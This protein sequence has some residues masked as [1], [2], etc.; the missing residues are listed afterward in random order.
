MWVH[1]DAPAHCRVGAT[2]VRAT[3]TL[4]TCMSA[5]VCQTSIHAMLSQKVKGW[6]WGQNVQHR[7]GW[8]TDTLTPSSTHECMPTAKSSC[9]FNLPA[10][11]GQVSHP[12]EDLGV[13]C[14]V[15]MRRLQREEEGHTE[16]KSWHFTEN[17]NNS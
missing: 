17:I 14:L 15:C 7:T 6:K 8:H 11:L 12:F 4:S 2:H 13:S 3:L 9:T 5:Y 1:K 16:T 10:D